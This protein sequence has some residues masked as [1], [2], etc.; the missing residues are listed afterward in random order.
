MVVVIGMWKRHDRDKLD[1]K[2]NLEKKVEKEAKIMGGSHLS[3][4]KEGEVLN[5]MK[6]CFVLFVKLFPVW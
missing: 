2:F 4:Q 1:D 6:N 5:G 3:N